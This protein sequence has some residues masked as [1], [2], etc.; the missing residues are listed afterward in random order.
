MLPSYRPFPCITKVI[1]Y[2]RRR[3]LPLRTSL[4]HE[5]LEKPNES[6]TWSSGFNAAALTQR[7]AIVKQTT[8]PNINHYGEKQSVQKV[9]SFQMCTSCTVFRHHLTGKIVA[10]GSS[11]CSKR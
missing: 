11:L 6:T 5:K 10:S 7:K 4:H 1:T 9:I 2:Q 3:K 8:T